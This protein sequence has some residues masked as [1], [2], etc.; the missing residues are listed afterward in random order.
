L[1]WLQY[2][3]EINGIMWIIYDM[4]PPGISGIKEGISER[5]N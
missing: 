1:Q 5:K 3:S 2:P 4:Q